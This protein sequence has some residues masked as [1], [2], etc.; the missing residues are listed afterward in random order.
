MALPVSASTACRCLSV[1]A[2]AIFLCSPD[3]C[4]AHSAQEIAC[5][6]SRVYRDVRKDAGGEQFCELLLPGSLVV[7]DGL[8]RFWFSEGHPG[9]EGMY[10]EGR[11]VGLWQE[12]DRFDRCQKRMYDAISPEERKRPTFKP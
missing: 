1:A 9:S 10:K 2:A 11:Q 5:G 4:F 12:C 3:I 6:D 8:Y 7:K